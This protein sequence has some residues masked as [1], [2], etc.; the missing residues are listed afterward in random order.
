[1]GV[2]VRV[3]SKFWHVWIDGAP[4]PRRNTKI[5]IGVTGEQ[6]KKSRALAEQV[7]HKLML[8]AAADT[9]GIARQK[10]K[11]SFAQHRA[12][13]SSHVTPMKKSQQQELSHL[14]QLGE[15]FDGYE[16]RQINQPLVREW[17]AHVSKKLKASTISR[18]E[19]LLR[20]VLNT[21]IP[22]YLA[23]HPLRGLANLKPAP[24]DMRVLTREEEA[25]LMKALHSDTDRALVICALDTL[26]RLSNVA[27]LSRAQDHGTY[28]FS[29]TK[30]GALRVPVSKRLRKALDALP[31]RGRFFFPDYA[32]EPYPYRVRDMFTAAC[33]R[34]KIQTGRNSGGVGFHTLRHTGATRML[35][36]GVDVK[37]VMRLG[38]WKSLDILER[39]LHPTD[40]AARTAVEAIGSK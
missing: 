26:L 6:K 24:N 3:G 29:D 21:A 23:D 32:E 10:P 17:R 14:G 36:A 28:L 25:R 15:F 8:E 2:Y 39:Y 30:T 9:F 4:R 1:M 5:P 37:T 18:Y 11:R 22:E 7:Y 38:G 40:E 31:D 20:H 34:A 27:K 13:Y 16:L 33:K 19:G 35:E 12:W